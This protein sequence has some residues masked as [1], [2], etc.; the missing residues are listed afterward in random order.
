MN[1]INLGFRGDETIL[2]ITKIRKANIIEFRV[3]YEDGKSISWTKGSSSTLVSE[4]TT[5]MGSKIRQTAE[6]ISGK[7]FDPYNKG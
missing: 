3:W 1:L 5:E 6:H 4:I 7:S 2:R